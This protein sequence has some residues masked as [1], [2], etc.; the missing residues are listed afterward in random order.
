MIPPEQADLMRFELENMRAMRAR[1]LVGRVRP[2]ES[3]MR[4]ISFG[5]SGT[6]CRDS[7]MAVY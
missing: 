3:K 4:T 2:A 7:I 1:Y 5:S 6:L